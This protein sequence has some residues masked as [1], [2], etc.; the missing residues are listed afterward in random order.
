[1][2]SPA[3]SERTPLLAEGTLEA[4]SRTAETETK[5]LAPKQKQKPPISDDPR[6]PRKS[7][8]T[9]NPRAN[10]P[11]PVPLFGQGTKA[12]TSAKANTNTNPITNRYKLSN[13]FLQKKVE[14]MELLLSQPE[15]DL[16]KLREFALSPGGLVNDTIRKRV[17]PKLVG[18]DH[19]Y[20]PLPLDHI[21][22]EPTKAS[23]SGRERGL[24]PQHHQQQQQ[25]QQHHPQHPQQPPP[26]TTIEI[27]AQHELLQPSEDEKKALQEMHSQTHRDPSLLPPSG[28]LLVES[29]DSSQIDRDVA[30]CTWHL[31]TG[32][33]RSRRSQHRSITQNS[34]R[35]N[36]Y[37][38]ANATRNQHPKQSQSRSSA[39]TPTSA[40]AS[41]SISTS[42]SASASTPASTP[43]PK[44]QSPNRINR[45]GH[46]QTTKYRRNR[47]ISVLLKKKQS[48]LA[49]L[50]NLA[51]VQS[52]DRSDRDA[53]GNG[54]NNNSNNNNNS[55]ADTDT[56]GNSKNRLRYYQG[57]HD[58]AC[59]FLHALG[60][61]ASHK[62]SSASGGQ[63]HYSAG[64]LEL[65]SKVLVQ[66]SF[67][68]FKDALRSDFLRLQTGLKLILFP[69]LRTIDMEIHD[70]LLD[71][72]M[73]PFFCLSWILTWFAHDVRDTAL[74]KR[75]FDAFLVAHPVLPVYA[76]LAMITH[77]YNRQIIL[78]TDC[79]F[80]ALHQ[81]LASLP[82]HSCKIGY[83]ERRMDGA[84]GNVVTYVS[85][86][87][88]D[89]GASTSAYSN[90]YHTTSGDN[91]TVTTNTDTYLE[92]Q[93]EFD[94]DLDDDDSHTFDT[95]SQ[96]TTETLYTESSFPTSI[97][98]GSLATSSSHNGPVPTKLT[99]G[100][101][102]AS[103]S[104]VSLH[105]EFRPCP[106]DRTIIS[107]EQP[108]FLSK[109]STLVSG[110]WN[111]ASAMD[112][113]STG[114]SGGPDPE[115]PNL[116]GTSEEIN[117]TNGALLL[118]DTNP[119]PFESVLDTAVQIMTKYPPGSLVKLAKDYY[120]DDWDSQLS[121][122]ANHAAA[123]DDNDLDV[124][125]L[126]GLLKPT[127]PA[128]S[129]LPTCTSDWLDKQKVR[130]DM[131]LKP[132]SR[133]DRRRRRNKKN[134]TDGTL[135]NNTNH[136]FDLEAADSETTRLLSVPAT[137]TDAAAAGNDP[138]DYV[139]SNPEDRAVAAI[140]YAPG[141][142]AKKRKRRLLR[143]RRR[144]KKRQRALAIGCG[145]V[146]LGGL[147]YAVVRYSSNHR[148]IAPPEH[149]IG[150]RPTTVADGEIP[151][152]PPTA[153]RQEAPLGTDG[154]SRA[155]KDQHMQDASADSRAS[156]SD[157]PARGL[158]SS[159]S[160]G[161]AE[162]DPT[163][164][165]AAMKTA[166]G[167]ILPRVNQRL[168]PSP[169]SRDKTAL[170]GAGAGKSPGPRETVRST[171]PPHGSTALRP[172]AALG[173]KRAHH[174]TPLGLVAGNETRRAGPPVSTLGKQGTTILL[175]L[176]THTRAKAVRFVRN[177][178]NTFRGFVIRLVRPGRN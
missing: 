10:H 57:Y 9:A 153:R 62:P 78:E 51:L 75:L 102:L 151:S 172:R 120:R 145:V 43:D 98:S 150:N 144:R 104:L 109:E 138:M 18:L 171:G 118:G 161:K 72:D 168:D 41:T 30:R 3:A 160:I 15:V 60:G 20:D 135:Y 165:D 95:R 162:R 5:T 142:E 37:H 170:P 49:N 88:G 110:T 6:T 117:N 149:G 126:I 147:V 50:I 130:Q 64:D 105:E 29:M 48:R 17:W 112:G 89:C 158:S 38:S 36:E 115:S 90:H 32:S 124:Q 67:S 25:H 79:D 107:T 39:S 169:P 96:F 46:P 81:C 24:P 16:W 108:D 97:H 45:R 26:Q 63:H 111:D 116:D 2:P 47:K 154:D 155:G 13:P 22:L 136:R 101:S 74:V 33:Q 1:M 121:L 141:L 23:A 80:A 77:P 4:A 106:T 178:W 133:K 146:L 122:L 140:G 7:N 59:I 152:E 123:S 14:D 164:A 40:T 87:E 91:H 19:N 113:T 68:H 65:P 28:T 83:K 134:P 173:D 166:A 82:K 156:A 73:E 143:N 8:G 139:R 103:G 53:S 148:S 177:A 27:D 34:T 58:V 159:S 42:A 69:L 157:R 52:Y 128:W 61:G 114:A 31:L 94:D 12:N 163:N 56:N 35:G 174:K 55:E 176:L 71:A 99:T 175:D 125:Q 11:L 131:G 129:V 86:E 137:T 70:H 132:T 167:I 21:V 100:A 66:V 93:S 92:E 54:N 84:F 85:D 127:P 119:V 76:A 44:Q